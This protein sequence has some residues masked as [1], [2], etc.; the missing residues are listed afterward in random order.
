MKVGI[1]LPIVL[2]IPLHVIESA[3]ML[4]R[5]NKIGDIALRLAN[6]SRVAYAVLWPHARAWHVRY[7]QPLLRG[8]PH[9]DEV[10]NV[11]RR[12]C[13]LAPLPSPAC[14]RNGMVPMAPGGSLLRAAS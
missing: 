5:Q 13:L 6:K 9:I 10:G 4:E 8:I 2:N 7:P 1:A 12:P 14:Q 11:L 3:D